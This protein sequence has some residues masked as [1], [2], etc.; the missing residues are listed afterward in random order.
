MTSG[1]WRSALRR[2]D[3]ETL[4]VDLHL[5]LVDDRLLVSVEE[6]DRVLDRHDVLVAL[7]VDVVDHRR[8]RRRFSRAGRPGAEDESALL[9]ADL[10]EDRRQEQ[11][12][13]RQDAGRDDA[14][15]EA[16][17]APLLEDVASE[18]SEVRHGVGDVD[19]EV[20]LELLLLPS[21]H[22][23]ERHRDRV[24][25]HEPPHVRHR[26]EHSVDPEDRERAHLEV[27]VGRLAL[28]GDLQEIV[29]VHGL[30]PLL[31]ADSLRRSG[32]EIKA[33]ER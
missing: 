7:R 2:A 19:L 21:G 14:Q 24:F 1:S 22:D 18:A 26:R 23:G 11:L 29:D 3:S 15:H 33:V 20:V 8:E 6:L 32:R 30:L 31:C 10:L 5:A 13:D 27:E 25:L 28:H 16:D 17:R 12:A 9:V 4:G